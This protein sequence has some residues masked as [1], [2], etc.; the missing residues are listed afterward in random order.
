MAAN[1]GFNAGSIWVELKANID[2]FRTGLKT[3]ISALGSFVKDVGAVASKV[4]AFGKAMASGLLAPV[5]AIGSLFSSLTSLK[6][7]IGALIVGKTFQTLVTGPAEAAVALERMAARAGIATDQLERLQFIV[8]AAGGRGDDVSI[9]LEKLNRILEDTRRGSQDF[10]PILR[11]LGLEGLS[12]GQIVTKILQNPNLSAG[13]L[14]K[15]GIPELAVLAKLSRAEIEKL[16]ASF[17]KLGNGTDSGLF[18]LGNRL[19]VVK[20]QLTEAFHNVADEVSKLI[21]PP[22]VKGLEFAESFIERHFPEILA[23]FDTVQQQAGQLFDAIKRTAQTPGKLAEVFRV[24]VEEIFKTIGGI[25]T[26]GFSGF[27][28]IAFASV[29]AIGAGIVLFLG[30]FFRD[31]WESFKVQL[32]NLLEKAG[33]EIQKWFKGIVLKFFLDLASVPG[34]GDFA[35]KKAVEV[36]NQIKE[37]T[38]D[39][40]VSDQEMEDQLVA[41]A[42][43][44]QQQDDAFFEGRLAKFKDT[45][46]NVLTVTLDS[47]KKI[48]DGLLG[49]AGKILS[50]FGFSIEGFAIEFGSNLKK[51]TAEREA[52]LGGGARGNGTIF[53]SSFVKDAFASVGN[54]LGTASQAVSDFKKAVERFAA[55]TFFNDQGRITPESIRQ[56]IFGKSNRDKLEEDISGGKL[57]DQTEDQLRQLRSSAEVQDFQ[58]TFSSGFSSAVGSGLREAI[59]SGKSAMETLTDIGNKLF[60]N[61]V[62]NFVNNLQNGIQT[63]LNTLF[64]AIGGGLEGLGSAIGGLLSAV[65]GVAGALL[66]K[67]KGSSSKSFGAVQDVITSSQALRGI[68]AGPESVA[69]AAVGEDLSRAITPLIEIGRAQLFALLRIANSVGGK[70]SGPSLEFVSLPTT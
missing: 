19:Q 69:I 61:M 3:A 9:G 11:E 59:L 2:S 68:V 52:A 10:L 5:R 36:S 48:S 50:T 27:A 4:T 28:K 49:S 67:R 51:R 17:V 12:L 62:D 65:A 43:R 41:L 7:I 55:T 32:N 60:G 22:L 15:L 47:I 63:G 16:E 64:S 58:D 53:G 18:K 30:P 31:L 56:G 45:A 54:M 6:A 42:D 46:G 20:T 66:A 38:R 40:R 35:S 39:Q 37:L 29:K 8:N 34:F 70:G 25:V 14:K 13:G 21:L 24:T 1:E 44:L 26:E 57:K 33:F 23:F